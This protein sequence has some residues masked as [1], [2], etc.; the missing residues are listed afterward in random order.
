MQPTKE[1][2]Q[3]LIN[4]NFE[5]WLLAGHTKEFKT[6]QMSTLAVRNMLWPSIRVVFGLHWD[7]EKQ[8]VQFKGAGEN[9]NLVFTFKFCDFVD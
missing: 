1:L 7:Y 3:K 9:S 6:W 4:S 8:C 5:V 2:L